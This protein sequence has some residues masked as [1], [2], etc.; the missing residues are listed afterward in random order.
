MHQIDIATGGLYTAK[1]NGKLTTVRVDEIR[2]NAN[3]RVYDVTNLKTGRRTY[4]R[5]ARKF[6]SRAQGSE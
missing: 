2:M 6:Q 1:V 4:F 5:S 3:R